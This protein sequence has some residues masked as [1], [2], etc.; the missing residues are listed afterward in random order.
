MENI[1]L[2]ITASKSSNRHAGFTSRRTSA[3][4]SSSPVTSANDIGQTSFLLKVVHRWY[5]QKH[6]NIIKV[7]IKRALNNHAI[8]VCNLIVRSDL[9]EI[10]LFFQNIT[11]TNN[12]RMPSTV[13][14]V[15]SWHDKKNRTTCVMGPVEALRWRILDVYIYI[16]H[17]HRQNIYKLARHYQWMVL[18]GIC[19]SKRQLTVKWNAMDTIHSLTTISQFLFL[20]STILW[21]GTNILQICSSHWVWRAI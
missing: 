6:S 12:H 10:E 1:I 19:D 21:T 14:D 2:M 4:K 8:Y 9:T 3:D 11:E 17:W 20:F 7:F 15:N 16:Y 5:N 18:K 13:I